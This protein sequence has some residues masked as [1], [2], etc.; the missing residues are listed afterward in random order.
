MHLQYQTHF[1]Y[2]KHCLSYKLIH[3]TCVFQEGLQYLAQIESNIGLS[4]NN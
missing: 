1:Y 4:I 3:Y 2:R